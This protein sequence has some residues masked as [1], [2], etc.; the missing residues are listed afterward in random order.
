MVIRSTTST[1]VLDEGVV[2]L[3]PE[4]FM[5]KDSKY[6]NEALVLRERSKE[7]GKKRGKGSSKYGK[8]EGKE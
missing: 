1:L 7:T 8:K 6:T 4:E 5:W 2:S 3:L